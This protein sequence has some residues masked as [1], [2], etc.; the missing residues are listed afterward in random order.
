M[1][2]SDSTTVIVLLSNL[3]VNIAA[4]ATERLFSKVYTKFNQYMFHQY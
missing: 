1:H 2:S 3:S 4:C